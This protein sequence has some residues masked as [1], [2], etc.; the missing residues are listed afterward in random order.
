M[1]FPEGEDDKDVLTYRQLKKL[2]KAE[3]KIIEKVQQRW[4]DK[5]GSECQ[6]CDSE[7]EECKGANCVD[8][9]SEYKDGSVGSKRSEKSVQ[10]E[11]AE[12]EGK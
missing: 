3:R 8:D 2:E 5:F 6:L 7:C 11:D 4:H 10:F 1:V 9:D 12:D